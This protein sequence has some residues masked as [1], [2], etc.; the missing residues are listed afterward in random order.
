LKS[1]NGARLT[2]TSHLQKKP[3]RRIKINESKRRRLVGHDGAGRLVDEGRARAVTREAVLVFPAAILASRGR[4]CPTRSRR[5]RHIQSQ[6][7]AR[8][9]R[10]LGR[11]HEGCGLAAARSRQ[12]ALFG[13][14]YAFHR[15]IH[16]GSHKVGRKSPAPLLRALPSIFGRYGDGRIR[17]AFIGGPA[18][19][20]PPDAAAEV[21][22]T[23]RLKLTGRVLPQSNVQIWRTVTLLVLHGFN[24]DRRDSISV[25]KTERLLLRAFE[26]AGYDTR[27]IE[28]FAFQSAPCFR[29]RNTR[30]PC[31]PCAFGGLY[32]FARRSPFSPPDPRARA[33]RYRPLLRDNEQLKQEVRLGEIC[34]VNLVGN[35]QI[36]A[37]ALQTLCGADIPICYFSQ[38]GWF[39]GIATGINSKNVFLRRTQFRFA[40]LERFALLLTRQLVAGKIRNQRTM[41]HRNHLE[42]KPPSLL[43]LRQMAEQSDRAESL[44][45]LLGIEGNPERHNGLEA[46]KIEIT[47]RKTLPDGAELRDP[48]PTR[49]SR[50]PRD[51][52]G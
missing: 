46:G 31:G 48:V 6:G 50:R 33:R 36:S 21:S 4:A 18:D 45:E 39:Y 37:Q 32:L 49:P 20:E 14:P 52:A 2:S 9:I 47:G 5:L 29:A 41:L 43:G 38:G 44:E 30:R 51:M 25:G 35:V 16:S 24:T 8:N 22:R 15:A 3:K 19:V 13:V 27:R 12:T 34:H 26:M 10:W 17:R 7:R 28:S 1:P 42:P 40:D 11:L 23:L